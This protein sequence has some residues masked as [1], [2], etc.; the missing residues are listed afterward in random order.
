MRQHSLTG[1][2]P[3]ARRTLKAFFDGCVDEP[4]S[5]ESS[6]CMRRRFVRIFELTEK[7]ASPFFDCYEPER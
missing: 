1:A 2:G 7:D 3:N 5:A 6:E 4:D